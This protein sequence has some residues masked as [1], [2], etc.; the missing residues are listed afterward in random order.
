MEVFC[1]DDISGPSFAFFFFLLLLMDMDERAASGSI[2]KQYIPS[3]SV[4]IHI[5][6]RIYIHI[7]IYT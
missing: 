7:H 4:Y 3:V 2:C 1:V 5:Y 6:T